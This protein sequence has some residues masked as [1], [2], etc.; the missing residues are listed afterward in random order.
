ML[1]V[2]LGAALAVTSATGAGLDQTFLAFSPG[3]L[4]EMSLLALAMGADV[5]YVATIH[6]LRV[7]AVISIAPIIFRFAS[8]SR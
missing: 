8:R 7:T 3:G 1:F 4:P 6:I 2:A 5:A